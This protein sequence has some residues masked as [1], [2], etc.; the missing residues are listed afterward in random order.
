MIF[1]VILS[2]Q[3]YLPSGMEKEILY[4]PQNQGK[5]KEIAER[6]KMLEEACRLKKKNNRPANVLSIDFK[7][8]S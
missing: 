5:E 6:I 2:P 4:Y 8:K 7:W 1:P 3:S